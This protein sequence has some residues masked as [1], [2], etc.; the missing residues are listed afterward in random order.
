MQDQGNWSLKIHGNVHS[1][2]P[3]SSLQV[4]S[5][6]QPPHPDNT[7][8]LQTLE[9]QNICPTLVFQHG[10]FG[11]KIIFESEVKALVEQTGRK[12]LT[13][14]TQNHT[15]SPSSSDCSYEAVSADLEALLLKLRLTPCVFIGHC[16]RGKTAMVLALQKPELVEHLIPLYISLTLTTAFPEVW[17]Y[18][19]TT[20]SLNIPRSCISLRPK[21]QLMEQLVIWQ[22]MLNNLIVVNGQYTW[23]VNIE[24]LS[25]QMD[26]IME[27]P[28]SLGSYSGPTLFLRGANYSLIQP[29]DYPQIKHLFPKAQILSVPKVDHWIHVDQSQ[30]FLASI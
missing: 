1:S 11:S 22:Y 2:P 9:G 5:L 26:T 8:L 3:N 23:K 21:I 30:A 7:T 6:S 15:D 16:M 10:L 17:T 18:M 13:V 27:F 14:D 25:H 29:H 12:V 24:A 20:K 28:R 4:P 19:E